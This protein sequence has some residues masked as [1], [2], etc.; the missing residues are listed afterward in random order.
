MKQTA[1]VLAV[2]LL[3]ACTPRVEVMVP[4][5]PI[6]VNLNVKV[7]HEIRVRVDREL[8]KL[9]EQEQELF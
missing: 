7:D 2:L 1:M 4:D 9:F 5:K 6:T 8:E 3:G